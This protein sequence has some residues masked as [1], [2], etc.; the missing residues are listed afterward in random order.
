MNT[1]PDPSEPEDLDGG[2]SNVVQRVGDQVRRT[3]GPWTPTIHTLLAALRDAGIREV[4]QPFGIDDEG[5]ELLSFIP[6]TVANYPLPDWVWSDSILIEAS[7]LLRRMHDATLDVGFDDAIWQTQSHEPQQVICHND[8]APYNMVFEQ[9]RLV[10]V[11]DFDTG[12]MHV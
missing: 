5:R 10:G 8:F 9:S 2:N 3:S 6:G 12:L 7:S 11:I 4:P 1:N